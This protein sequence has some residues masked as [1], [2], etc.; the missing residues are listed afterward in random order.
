[1]F[2]EGSAVIARC[3]LGSGAEVFLTTHGVVI[4][5]ERRTW[6]QFGRSEILGL[7]IRHRILWLPLV[8][9]GII[10]PLALVAL[11]KTFASFWLLFATVL[12]GL[13]L[14]YYGYTGTDAF[15]VTTRLKDHDFFIS[16]IT[17]HLRAF[18]TFANRQLQNDDPLIY[19]PMDES[20]M[21]KALLEDRID[22]GER[23]YLSPQPLHPGVRLMA[24]NARDHE[25]PLRFTVDEAS[26]N[27][28]TFLQ[29][30]LPFHLFEEVE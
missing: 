23:V 15:S 21:K 18:V 30:S 11:I 24:I 4:R 17:P 16:A 14:M 6:G 27:V 29:Q 5:D 8:L 22:E 25:V 28:H 10:T 9:G 1:M 2:V 7:K 12:V 3:P 19:L 13:F 20:A 26:E